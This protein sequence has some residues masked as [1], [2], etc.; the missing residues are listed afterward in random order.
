MSENALTRRLRLAEAVCLM[1]GWS[2]VHDATERDKATS[3]LW[4]QWLG[5]VPK[6]FTD[7]ANH[8]ELSDEAITALANKRDATRRATLQRFGFARRLPGSGGPPGGGAE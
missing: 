3:E 6:N 4:R 5:A 2:P 1:Y 7:P 8:P